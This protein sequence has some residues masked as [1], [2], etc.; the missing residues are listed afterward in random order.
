MRQLEMPTWLTDP[1][2]IAV[3]PLLALVALGFG[4]VRREP[5][6]AIAASIIGVTTFMLAFRWS[7]DI[8]DGAAVAVFGAGIGASVWT[9][10]TER[11]R[12]RRMHRTA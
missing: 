9:M 6:W 11:V 7:I 8:G 4:L 2:T 12:A 1:M 5:W 10:A 3:V